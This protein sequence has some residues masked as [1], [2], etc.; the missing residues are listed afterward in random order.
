[1]RISPGPIVLCV[2]LLLA[3]S[4]V[5]GQIPLEIRFPLTES[6]AELRDPAP[7]VAFLASA[8]LPGAGQ[9]LQRDERWVPYVALEAWAVLS[10]LTKRGSARSLERQYRDLSAVPRRFG[11]SP[12]RDTVFEY[13]ELLTNWDASGEFDE[14]PLVPGIQP[15]QDV[16]TYNGS[17]WRLARSLYLPGGQSLP[18]TSPQ[19]QRAL[20]H[21]MRHAIPPAFAWAWGASR[22]EQQAYLEL[23]D[24]SD[25]AY[26]TATQLLGIIVANHIVSAVDALVTS[27]LRSAEGTGS[28][29]FRL[30]SDAESGAGGTR[31]LYWARIS[32]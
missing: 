15:E 11:T 29:R 21:Y 9:Y 19:Y 20:A 27:R 5:A 22:L 26:R 17:V 32:W 10:F 4:P 18:P 8:I 1:M 12:R 31:W 3:P 16:T 2:W 28:L 24:Q 14:L 13:Y 25:E 23:F 7:G 30:G 6:Q